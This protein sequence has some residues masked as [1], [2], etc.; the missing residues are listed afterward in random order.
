MENKNYV[1]N[2]YENT[3]RFSNALWAQR[4]AN[5]NLT[6]EDELLCVDYRGKIQTVKATLEKK[7]TY[8]DHK[9]YIAEQNANIVKFLDCRITNYD[10]KVAYEEFCSSYSEI[11]KLNS[12]RSF[13]FDKSKTELIKVAKRFGNELVEIIEN[14]FNK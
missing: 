11:C 8:S 10:L 5:F 2:D 14:Y 9:N 12:T 3:K 7:K 6:E 13:D 1:K 4:K